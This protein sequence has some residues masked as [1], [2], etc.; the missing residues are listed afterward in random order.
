MAVHTTDRIIISPGARYI[1]LIRIRGDRQSRAE[2][3]SRLVLTCSAVLATIVTWVWFSSY[4]VASG[5]WHQSRPVEQSPAAHA[6]LFGYV[7][8]SL[9]AL[10]ALIGLVAVIRGPRRAC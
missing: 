8:A 2:D 9:W 3:R 4:M 10:T 6:H 5:R 7:A 1:G